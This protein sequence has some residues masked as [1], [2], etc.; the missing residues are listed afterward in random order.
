MSALH[1]FTLRLSQLFLFCTLFSIILAQDCGPSNPCESGCCSKFGFCGYGKDYCAPDNC[2]FN[3][4]RKAECDPGGLGSQYVQLKRCPLNICCSKHGFCGTTKEFCGKKQMPKP[5]ECT[6]RKNF[7]QV[8]GYYEGWSMGRY[9][10]TFNPERIP[11]GVYT[12][13]NFA[14]ASIDPKTFEVRP[15]SNADIAMYKRVVSLKRREP[16]LKVLIAIGGWTFNDPGPTQ[17]VFS[18][19]A[20]SKTNQNKFIRSLISFMS[21]YGFDGIDLDWEYPVAPDRSGRDEDYKNFPEFL[22]NMKKALKSSGRD[23]ISITIPASLW[24]LKHFDIV[25]MEKHID[26]FNVMSYDLHG[27][28]DL[29]NQWVGPLLNAHTNLTEIDDALDLLWLNKIN[30][31][32]VVMGLAFYG[33]SFRVESPSCTEPGCRYSSGS[34]KRPCSQEAGV[35]LNSEIDDVLKQSTSQPKLFKKEAVK[36]LVYGDNNWV[37]YDDAETLELKTDFA[38]KRCLGGVMVWAISHDTQDAK[39]STALGKHAPQSRPVKA[40]AAPAMGALDRYDNHDQCKWTNCGE[41]CPSGWTT[42]RRGDDGARKGEIMKDGQGCDGK[43]MHTFCCP[44][45]NGIPTCGWYKHRNGDCTPACPNNWVEVGG[46]N[47]HCYRTAGGYFKGYQAACCTTEYGVGSRRGLFK[48]MGLYR[49]CDWGQQPTCENTCSNPRRSS[50]VASSWQG[51]GATTCLSSKPRGLCCNHDDED[52]QWQDCKWY[53][54]LGGGPGGRN[55]CR[56]GCP[57][58]KVRVAMDATGCSNGAA[59]YCCSPQSRSLRPRDEDPQARRYQQAL[60][61]FARDP[62]CPAGYFDY[63][64][65]EPRS[66][67]LSGRASSHDSRALTLSSRL[68]RR[69][70]T[71]AD[72]QTMEEIVQAMAWGTV[73]YDTV[74]MWEE[75]ITTRWVHPTVP[76]VTGY[77]RRDNFGL[78]AIGG[79]AVAVTHFLCNLDEVNSVIGGA[80]N[81]AGQASCASVVLLCEFEISIQSREIEWSITHAGI[82]YSGIIRFRNYLSLGDWNAD[83]PLQSIIYMEVFGFAQGCPVFNVVTQDRLLEALAGTLT[84][85]DT[86]HLIDLQTMPEWYRAGI[87]GLLADGSAATNRIDPSFFTDT[88]QSSAATRVLG[89]LRAPRGYERGGRFDVETFEQRIMNGLGSTRN[90]DVFV[91]ATKEL[92]C[93]KRQLFGRRLTSRQNPIAATT[94]RRL[95]VRRPQDADTA[96]TNMNHVIDLFLYLSHPTIHNSLV[97]IM[98]EMRTEMRLAEQAHLAIHNVR[99]PA[100][101]HFDGWQASSRT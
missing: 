18:D 40:K 78:V 31:S 10:N 73:S 69:S 34:A 6:G 94:M 16:N 95:M 101:A 59:A 13:I 71:V 45:G 37:A 38:F 98:T 33:R 83:N 85:V 82:T 1:G 87:A 56:S 58:D 50:L 91:L 39:Y 89:P 60:S 77:F 32:K 79:I 54:D 61:A 53:K 27:T 66:S 70:A 55:N 46:N 9:C 47:Q 20:R 76:L 88:L 84:E 51:S 65:I 22:K 67:G 11:R 2:V 35:I 93:I 74:V 21:T 5:A 28:W 43:A 30:P 92:N 57:P 49:N 17:Y 8:V 23:E 3:C 19:I 29:T 62:V 36:T 72:T 15:E 86:E 80:S 96:L 42:V 48:N 81:G 4:D 14:F 90:N 12:H 99:V 26:F 68:G 44:A 24:Y 100:V 97:N 25:A 75:T 41:P 7:Q 63:H 64:H 52:W